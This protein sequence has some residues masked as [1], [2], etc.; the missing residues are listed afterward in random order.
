VALR[1]GILEVQ[2][3][4]LPEDLGPGGEADVSDVLDAAVA[5]WSAGRIATGRVWHSPKALNGSGR[6]GDRWQGEDRGSAG[7]HVRDLGDSSPRTGA[8][9]ALPSISVHLPKD[10]SKALLL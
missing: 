5:A 10:T 3:I 2:G 7:L 8:R 1:R 9:R 6:S 4:V